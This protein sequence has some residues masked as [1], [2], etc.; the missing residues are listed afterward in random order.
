M[1]YCGKPAHRIGPPV[2]LLFALSQRFDEEA[3]LA[4]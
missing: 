4:A 2:A 3:G 1:E